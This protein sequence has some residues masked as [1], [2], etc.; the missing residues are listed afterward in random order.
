MMLV[1]IENE[2]DYLLPTLKQGA[3]HEDLDLDGILRPL[4]EPQ[5]LTLS[6]RENRRN[7]IDSLCSRIRLVSAKS[8][9]VESNNYR[10]RVLGQLLEPNFHQF[11]IVLVY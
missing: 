7:P 10:L 6:T 4:T 9:I 5:P 8:L 1:R 2:Q 11:N 3:D